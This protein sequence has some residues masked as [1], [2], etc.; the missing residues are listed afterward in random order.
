MKEECFSWVKDRK[1]Y[2]QIYI[3]SRENTKMQDI[4]RE[5][6]RTE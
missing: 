2:I 3:R 6:I 1:K 4:K 5:K